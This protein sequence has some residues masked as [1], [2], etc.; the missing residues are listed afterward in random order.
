MMAGRGGRGGGGGGTMGRVTKLQ[1]MNSFVWD[2]RHQSGLP[3]TPGSFQAR[4]TVDGRT[5]TQPFRVLIDPRLAEEGLTV[6]DLQ[7]QFDHNTRMRELVAAV[8]QLVTRVRD[9]QNRLK[10]ATGAEAE[11]AKRVEAIA[12][13]LLTEPVRYGKPGLQ[14]HVSYLAGMTGS[15]DQKVGRDA[16]DRYAV[17]KKEFDAIRAEA[18]SVLGR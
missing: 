4:L 15:V 13:K 14:A 18:E 5:L 17:L 12:A 16:L 8:N 1:G 9:A 6:A 11:M 7:E 2:V 3:A 10:G